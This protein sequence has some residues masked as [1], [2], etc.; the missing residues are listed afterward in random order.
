M[1]K[2]FI[3]A[4]FISITAI[5]EARHPVVQESVSEAESF[6]FQ[7]P[8]P[9]KEAVRDVAAETYKRRARPGRP[10]MAAPEHSPSESS[11]EVQYW[12]YSE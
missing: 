1:K 10:E 5:A 6:R 2:I 3:L 9:E 7:A 8:Q 12:Q 11:S 4:F